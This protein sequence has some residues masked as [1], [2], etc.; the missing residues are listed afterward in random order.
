MAEKRELILDLL[1]KN[2]MSGATAGAAR[3]IDKVGSAADAAG[4]KTDKFGKTTTVAGSAA[5]ALGEEASKTARRIS[6]LDGEIDQVSRSIRSMTEELADADGAAARLDISKGIRK[7]QADLKRLTSARGELS[8]DTGSMIPLSSILPDVSPAVVTKWSTG[9]AAG[10]KS[11]MIPVLGGV[12]IA[13]AP[14]LGAAIASAVIG[15]AG[16]AGVIGGVMLVA[17]S[18]A[19]AKAGTILGDTLLADMKSRAKTH[20][21]QPVLSSITRIQRGYAGLTPD[22]DRIFKASSRFVGPLTAGALGAVQK[23]TG[24]FADAAEAAGPVIDILANRLPDLGDAVAD[25]MSSLADNGVDAAVALDIAL[26]AVEGTIRV[27]GGAVNALT[28]SFGWLA[29]N[30]AFGRD[31]Q[32]EYLRLAANAKIAEEANKDVAGSMG[33]VKDAGKGVAGALGALVEETTEAGKASKA[34]REALDGQR[35]A[36]LEL[37][38]AIRAQTDPVFALRD[39]QD[40]LAEAHKKAAEATQKHGK[41]SREAREASRDLAN[42]ANDLQGAVG[43]LGGSFDGR[44]TPAMRANYRAAGLTEAQINDVENEFRAAKRAGDA[45]AKT[46]RARVITDYISRYSS[47]VMSS[48]QKSYEDTK[49]SIAKRA[50]GGPTSRGTPYWVG[51]NGPELHVPNAA[52]RVMSAAASR[53]AVR[54]GSPSAAATG[55]PAGGVVARLELV[56]PEEVR[57][58]FRKM[59]RT[60]NILPEAV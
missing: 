26:N 59:V 22:I 41:N 17:K 35:G 11:A 18:E 31:A 33:T 54:S 38:N 45:Y 34:H 57:T 28:E 47:V 32:L 7:A 40:N 52:G 25:V 19:V 14:I 2:K 39:A 42:A 20:F 8:K 50:S 9:L 13:A 27:I 58:W 55:W 56:G 48:A 46:Y 5:S 44:L 23:I 51:E 30:G 16:A 29:K 12:G 10:L 49:R 37:S 53:G 43:A 6:N 4:R 60:M 15:G 1:A 36:L 24:G 3:D 21:E